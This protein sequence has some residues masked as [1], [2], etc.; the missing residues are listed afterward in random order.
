[1]DIKDALEILNIEKFNGVEETKSRF[2]E[3][4]HQYH[5]DKNSDPQSAEKF[6]E[7]LK[8][9][10]FVLNN[11][12]DVFQHFGIKREENDEVTARTAIDNMD[13]IFD[14][15]FGF[16][17]SGRVLGYQEPQ[18][19]YISIE[20]FAHGGKKREKLISY[21][22]CSDCDGGGAAKGASA[23][24]C[25]Y[26]FGNGSVKGSGC[27]KCKGRGR[28]M[29]K[30][31][32][33]CDGFGRLKQTRNQEFVLPVGMRP[34]E[35]YT[36]DSKDVNSGH[37]SQ[38]FLEPRPLRDGIFQIENYDLLCEYHLD[39][40]ALNSDTQLLLTT[41]FGNVRLIIPAL[42]KPQNQ[43]RLNGHG[44]YQ[45]GG[46]RTRGDLVVTLKEKKESVV[47]R[48]FKSIFGG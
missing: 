37:K 18:V 29:A 16:S 43:I 32:H 23:Q 33:G 17:R 45:D 15:I 39:F 10:E 44:L 13:D 31:C 2:R 4:A 40:K 8:A 36:I 5:P 27:P 22:I 25:S 24:V 1:M 30:M 34:G 11:I 35:Q 7:I 38:I 21:R 46:K 20:E 6:R 26:C 48:F 28:V 42:A 14:D 41:P 9:Y 3:L 47:K 12:T 19:L